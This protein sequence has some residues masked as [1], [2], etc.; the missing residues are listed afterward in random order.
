MA[1]LMANRQRGFH[2]VLYNGITIGGGYCVKWSAPYQV[3]ILIIFLSGSSYISNCQRRVFARF[4]RVN[5][6]SD[7]THQ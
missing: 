3:K 1:D 6:T 7:D 2:D 5:V 4:V